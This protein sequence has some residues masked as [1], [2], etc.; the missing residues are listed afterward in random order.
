MDVAYIGAYDH[1]RGIYFHSGIQWVSIV[2]EKL[3]TVS[4]EVL[5]GDILFILAGAVWGMTAVYVK[6][7][8]VWFVRVFLYPVILVLYRS[9]IDLSIRSKRQREKNYR[10]F[11]FLT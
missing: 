4:F 2:Y 8:L 7:Y 5:P 11:D 1:R 3:K 9:I 10:S 6:K